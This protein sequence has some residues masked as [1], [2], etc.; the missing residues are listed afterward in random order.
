[1]REEVPQHPGAHL[2][3]MRMKAPPR[4]KFLL[5]LSEQL[6]DAA[7]QKSVPPLS[8][9]GGGLGRDGFVGL[10][11]ARVSCFAVAVVVVVVVVGLGQ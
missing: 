3:I 4:R 11:S 10:A 7:W 9:W 1:M 6:G 8:L 5:R 2:G